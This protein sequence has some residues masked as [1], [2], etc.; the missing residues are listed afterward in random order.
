MRVLHY[1]TFVLNGVVCLFSAS[2]TQATMVTPG[3]LSVSESGAAAYTIP[4]QTPPG[5]AGIE[6]KLALTYNSQG[7]NGLLGVGWSLSGLSAITRCLRTMAQDGFRGSVNFDTNDRYCL[8]GQRLM[9]VSG[10]NGADGAQYRT[11][12]DSF[13]KIISY[14]SAGNG[15]AWFKVWTKSGQIMEYGNTADS[16]IEAQGKASSRVWAMNKLQDTKS[17]YLTVTYTEDN[18]NGN[19]YPQRIDYTGNTNTAQTTNNSVQFTYTTRSDI[20]PLY[21][22]GSVIKNTVRPIFIKTFAAGSAVSEYRLGYQ[23]SSST[24]RLRLSSVT[25]YTGDGTGSLPSTTL[26]W[27]GD[28]VPGW[29]NSVQHVLG[30]GGTSDLFTVGDVNGDVNGDGK[31]DLIR[32]YR[33]TSDMLHVRVKLSNGNGTFTAMPDQLLGDGTPI[34]NPLMLADV[35]GDGKTDLIYAYKDGTGRIHARVKLSNGDGTFKSI[36]DRL[37]FDPSAIEQVNPDLTS[38][39]AQNADGTVTT[40]QVQS[41]S[42]STA[43]NSP[44]LKQFMLGDINGDGKIDF[45]YSYRDA[46]NYLHIRQCVSYGDGLFNVLPDQ[47]LGETNTVDNPFILGDIN[48]DGKADLIRPYRNSSVQMLVSVRLSKG[49]GTFNLLPNQFLG[50]GSN[51]DNPFITGDVN[52]DGKTD[53]IYLIPSD[54][55]GMI[56]RTKMSD[57]HL[58][59]FITAINNGLGA[60]TSI[61]Y[62]PLTNGSIYTK[63]TGTN[64]SSYPTVDLQIPLYAVYQALTPNGLGNQLTT[65]YQYGGL[66]TDMNGRGFL[67]FRWM[68]VT[69]VQTNITQHTEYRQDW[70]Y[71]GLPNVVRKVVGSNGLLSQTTNSYGCLDSSGTNP[72]VVANGNGRR[73]FPYVSKS[74]ETG[75]D[76]NGAALPTVTTTN[77]FDSYG[78]ATQVAVSTGDGYGKTTTNIYTND[79]PNWYLGRLVK[80]QVTST[81]P[82]SSATRT[83]AFDYDAATGLLNKE[84]VEPSDSNLCVVT[85]YTLDSY[86]NKTAATTRNCNGSAGSVPAN[87]SEAAAPTGDAVFAARTASTAFDTRGQFPLSSTNALNQTETKT[88][89]SQFGGMLTLTGPNDLT[90]QW[91]YD[92]FGRKTLEKRAD[93]TQTKS[94]YLFCSGINSGTATCTAS[95]K[96]LVQVT[97]LGTDGITPNGAAARTYFDMLGREMRSETT[98]F[99]GTSTIVSSKTY[100]S[101]GRLYQASRPYYSTQTP[102]WTTYS[103]DT[104]GR[105]ITEARP[106]TTTTQFTYNG[107][108]TVITN[109]LNQT[110]T[111]TKNSQGQLASVK[112][113]QNNLLTYQYDA[114]GNL[115]KTVDPLGNAT[116]LVYD[117]KGRKTQMI[118]PDMG[119]WS[120]VY[121]AIGELVK[122][123]DA[124]NQAVTMTYD[125]L[126]RMISRNESD[127]ISNWYYDAY[128]DGSA[129]AKGIGKLCQATAGNGYIRKE[130]YDNGGRPSS[131]T[132]T[133][134]AAYTASVTFDANGRVATQTYPAGLVVKYVY[135]SLGYLKEVRNNATNALYWQANTMD[136]EGHLLQQTY[137]NNV[138]TQQTFETTTSRLKQILAGA[139]NAVQNLAYQYDNGGNLTSRQD[140]NQNLNETFLYDG[141]NRL[142]TSTVNSSGAGIISKTYGFDAIG[143]ITSRS[144][145]GTYTYNAS[146]VNSIRP[147]AVQEI[148]LIAGGKR[149]Y[150]FD[151]NGNL[152]SEIQKDSAGNI[153]SGK[154]RTATW[155]SFNMPLTV[156]GN[157]VSQSFAYSPEHQRLRES[158]NGTTTIYLNGDNSGGLL[159]E[160]DTKADGTIEHRQFVTAG[161]QV[162]A[163]VKQTGATIT[164]RYFHRDNLGSTTAVTDETG[165]VVEQ[166]AYEPFGKRRFAPGNDD[167]NNTIKGINTTR[168]FTNHEHLDELGIIHMNG[169]IYDPAIG[170]F[171]SPDPRIQSGDN[172]QSFNRYSYIWN[173]PLGGVD[174]NGYSFISE[175]WHDIMSTSLGRIMVTAA[176]TYFTGYYNY[177]TAAAPSYGVFGATAASGSLGN[178]VAA[179]FAGGYVGSGGNFNAGL[180]GGLAGALFY[181]AGSYGGAE[182]SFE[183]TL[184]HGA[185]GCL[186]AAAGGGNCRQGALAASFAQGVG[187]HITFTDTAANFIART[188]L[189]GTASVIGGGKFENGAVTAAYGYL[190]NELQHAKFNRSTG[191]LSIKDGDTGASAS[192]SFFSGTGPD[193][194]IAPGDYAVLS[195]GSKDGFRLE[196]YDSVFGNDINDAN[197]QSLLRLHGPGRS[198]GCIT[199]KDISDWANVKA[200]IQN[201]STSDVQVNAYKSVTLPGGHLFSR[202]PWGTETVKYYGRLRVE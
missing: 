79:V 57:G 148:A 42:N 26:V 8:D 143:N 187:S 135:T 80:A 5:T 77:Q 18:A 111:K 63:D 172:L 136:A 61:N 91:Q 165:A 113:N 78:N 147:H 173:N 192:G 161:G 96:Y 30:D 117:S 29:Y 41:G 94:E 4:I 48:G 7:G 67:G 72:C 75:F 90:T 134:D 84:I 199:A 89:D 108:T 121:N 1:R 191:V 201:T 183:R 50:D 115:T 28:Y 83:S 102:Q 14:G 85:V 170:R 176:V 138:V 164:T 194:Q 150:G 51:V 158:V 60:T 40:M 99:D 163:V 151:A 112:D 88:F 62:R 2:T 12:R 137:G 17:N 24:G 166:L 154:G 155:T 186:S 130:S 131:T 195:R 157:G 23:A 9:V 10:S 124:K 202:V 27:E 6:P 73:Y 69:S 122:Q 198:F 152:T 44:V 98:G 162:V 139:G 114:F 11:E 19:F 156:T 200:L 59:D 104:L 74:V 82:T 103:Y 184:A 181:G 110:Q 116:T 34:A 37:L 149:Q 52:G 185:A 189:G 179:G 123:T 177:G 47:N 190:F 167:P 105:I 20:T 31:T 39:D 175:M 133:I 81:T 22:A 145:V 188:V 144:D 13:T 180:Q 35:N 171:M 193:N 119:T 87:N 38:M 120:Y 58:P 64:A 140:S 53:L 33:D 118:D 126:G 43:L 56:V 159:Y 93:G 76:L 68:N 46:S 174:P 55:S 146:G 197:G 106:D 169:R 101:L 65:N 168:G 129:C 153:L 127:L 70:P 49:D 182:G 54:T 16:R 15:P 141:L 25:N 3:Q 128:K 125:K 32:P 21:H 107:L 36:S 109:A 160:K 45:I 142:T 100:D 86:G 178:A 66:K 132:T 95:A 71:V 196:P 92:K 97:P